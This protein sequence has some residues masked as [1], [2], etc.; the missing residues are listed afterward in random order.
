MAMHGIDGSEH[1]ISALLVLGYNGCVPLSSTAA[2]AMAYTNDRNES[3]HDGVAVTKV[4]TQT[5]AVAFDRGCYIGKQTCF[6]HAWLIVLTADGLEE[7]LSW[8]GRHST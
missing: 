3:V 6:W 7:R 1:R 2:Q 5:V 8:H 4:S